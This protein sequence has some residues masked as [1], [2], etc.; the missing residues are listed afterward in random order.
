MHGSL[1]RQN[2]SATLAEG[3]SPVPAGAGL[4]EGRVELG[5]HLLC[6]AAVE[7]A[8]LAINDA[9]AL[10]QAVRTFFR[11]V[12]VKTSLRYTLYKRRPEVV[13]YELEGFRI[14]STLDTPSH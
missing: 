4:Y 10:D 12:H 11:F 9:A 3:V 1:A 7:V 13:Q 5:L 14:V 6:G 8:G 2:A